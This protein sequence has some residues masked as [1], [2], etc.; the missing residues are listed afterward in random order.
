VTAPATLYYFAEGYT[1]ESFDEYLTIQ[2]PGVITSEISIRY[3]LGVGPPVVVTHKV[4]PLHR[5]TVDVSDDV[6][7]GQEVSAEVE[8]T[9]P[10]VVERPMYFRYYDV[11]DGG[12]VAAGV[13]QAATDWYFAEGFTG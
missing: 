5:V 3:L 4:P 1:G 2:N 9:L 11:W 8:A 6:G 10:V 13:T 12:H 7:R